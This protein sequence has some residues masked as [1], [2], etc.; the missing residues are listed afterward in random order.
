MVW[1][2]T[3][4]E[5]AQTK[6][7]ALNFP[8]A[9]RKRIAA[10]LPRKLNPT[11]R[12]GL[13]VRIAERILIWHAINPEIAPDRANRARLAEEAGE[14]RKAVAQIRKQ[15][16]KFKLNPARGPHSAEGALHSIVSRTTQGLTHIA[17]DLEMWNRLWHPSTGGRP[18]E[19]RVQLGMALKQ[20]FSFYCGQKSRGFSKLLAALQDRRTQ[21]LLRNVP[22]LPPLKA[23]TA[24]TT[25]RRRLRRTKAPQK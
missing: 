21:R 13:A 8:E 12:N 2:D 14:L 1:G 5:G 7:A 25:K 23:D 15:L 16:E 20:E 10:A 22:V 19:F 6:I 9:W 4:E 17:Q 3:S 11:H 24:G 18:A